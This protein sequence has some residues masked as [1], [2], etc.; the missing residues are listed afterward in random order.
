MEGIQLEAT[1]GLLL[2]SDLT[3]ARQREGKRRL[4]VHTAGDILRPMSP[5]SRPRRCAGGAVPD[6]GGRTAWRERSA[7]PTFYRA[8]GNA[9]VGL[10]Q[11]APVPGGQA[12]E[13]LMAACSSFLSVGKLMFFGS[14]WC[15]P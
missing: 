2:A 4:E 13:S 14:P 12:I 10:P 11:T 6:G 15:R 3:G 8:F 5:I 1:L 7:P 9:E